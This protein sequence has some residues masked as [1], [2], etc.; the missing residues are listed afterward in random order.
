[1]TPIDLVYLWCDDADPKWRAKRMATAE[2]FGVANDSVHNGACRYRGGDMLRYSL[3]SAAQS[4]PWVRNIFV[5]MDDDQSAQLI[6]RRADPEFIGRI[7]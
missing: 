5:V 7:S 1:M 6:E 4:I 3:R 2:K